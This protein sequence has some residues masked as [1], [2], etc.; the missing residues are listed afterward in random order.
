MSEDQNVVYIGKKPVMNYVLAVMTYLHTPAAEE[1]VLKARGK[2]IT[3]AVDVA[4]ISRRRFIT[5]LAID[6]IKIGTEEMSEEEGRTRAVSFIEIT[7]LQPRAVI[8]APKAESSSRSVKETMDHGFKII[9]IE[10]IGPVYAEKLNSLNIYTAS[11]LLEIGGTPLGRKELA[12]K[13]GISHKLILEWVDQADLLRIKGIGEEYSDLLE[14]AGVDT[15]VEL[16]KRVPEN[17]HTK[18]LAV[19]EAKKLVQR[20]PTLDEVKQWIEE[21]KKLP[22]KIHY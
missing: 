11:D 21:A 2:S 13:T 4:E 22:R 5:S 3:T 14:A 12:E 6:K 18:M 9:D 8:E 7:L 20:P 16:A 19:N 10:G 15:V 1:V 17:L